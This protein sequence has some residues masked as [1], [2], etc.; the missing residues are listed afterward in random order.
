[1]RIYPA[2]AVKHQATGDNRSANKGWAH[3]HETAAVIAT[4]ISRHC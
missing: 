3:H 2:M 4:I 1:M